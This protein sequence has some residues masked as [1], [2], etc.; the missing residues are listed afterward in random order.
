MK[1]PGAP[2]Y[3]FV[4]CL[5]NNGTITKPHGFRR[6]I[7]DEAHMEKNHKAGIISLAKGLSADGR[8]DR[9]SAHR[10]SQNGRQEKDKYEI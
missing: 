5:P 2:P 4:R 9:G 10:T 8:V 1:S 3:M 6:A 7:V